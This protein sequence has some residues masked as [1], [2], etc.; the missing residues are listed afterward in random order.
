MYLSFAPQ[1][2]YPQRESPGYSMH[3]RLGGPQNWSGSCG[4]EKHLP[5]A[6]NP[7][8]FVQPV[9]CSDATDTG[10]IRMAFTPLHIYF[11]LE[12]CLELL[13][14]C[15]PALNNFIPLQFGLTCPL[16]GR[17]ATIPSQPA[18]FTGTVTQ[19]HFTTDD[20]SASP[21]W[22]QAP[23]RSHDQILISVLTFTVLSM[24]GAPSDERSGLSSVL[25]T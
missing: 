22:C 9:A 13:H 23:S 8:P 1:P 20:Q 25:V 3:R 12:F 18:T 11:S 2:F 17:L 14:L 7:N 10:V 19:S 6:V 15:G 21:S 5:P 16:P 4:E 24:S